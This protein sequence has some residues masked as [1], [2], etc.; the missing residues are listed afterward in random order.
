MNKK[1]GKKMRTV[2]LQFGMLMITCNDVPDHFTD[3]QVKKMAIRY[4]L[5]KQMEKHK[6]GAINKIGCGG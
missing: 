6:N 4:L 2:T 1:G 3:E 5:A